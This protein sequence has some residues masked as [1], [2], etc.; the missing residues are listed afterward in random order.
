MEVTGDSIE[1]KDLTKGMKLKTTQLGR[2]VTSYL[3]ESPKQGKGLKSTILVDT[4][5]SEIG[6]FDEIGSIYAEDVY[7]AMVE[8]SGN[9]QWVKVVGKP[10][11]GYDLFD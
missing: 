6:M 8:V 5:G 10:E 3:V 2:P 1:Y 4:K 9:P 7:L 11:S